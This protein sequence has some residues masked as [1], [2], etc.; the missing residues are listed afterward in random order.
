M[1]SDIGISKRNMIL[2]VECPA[3]DC[4]YEGPLKCANC[5]GLITWDKEK[6]IWICK[7]CDSDIISPEMKQEGKSGVPIRCKDCGS[8]AKIDIVALEG[9]DQ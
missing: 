4:D 5:G 3:S 8:K 9:E 1:P 7:D 6:E 2:W